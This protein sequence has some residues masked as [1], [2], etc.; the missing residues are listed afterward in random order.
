MCIIT[1]DWSLDAQFIW[2]ESMYHG[3]HF[4][5]LVATSRAVDEE[6][7]TGK[8]EMVFV[9]LSDDWESTGQLG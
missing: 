3:C 4:A 8:L 1:L 2:D 9:A 5:Q 7:L 6:G